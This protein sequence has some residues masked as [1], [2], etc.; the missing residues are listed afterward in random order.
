MMNDAPRRKLVELVARHGRG[1]AEEPRRCEAL[2]RDHCGEYRR[3]IS[4]LTS[5]AE[6]HAA[7]D[8][9]TPQ[10]GAPRA[11]LLGRLARRL[12]DHV[13]LTE[14]A[15][16]WAVNSWA[17]ALGVVS[18][19]ELKTLESQVGARAE[20]DAAA[21]PARDAARQQVVTNPSTNASVS[22]VVAAQ[23]GGDYASI[24]EALRSAAPGARLLVRPGLY[25]EGVVIDRQVEIVGDG[26]VEKII[27]RGTTSSCFEM[28][29]ERARVAGLTLRGGGG[30]GGGAAFFAVDIARG[31]LVL[32]D[33]RIS[34]E[35]LSCVAVHGERTAPLIRRCRIHDGADT[36][37]YFFDGARG[38]VEDCEVEGSANVGVAITAGADPV[39]RRSRIHGGRNAG[40]VAWDGGLGVLEECEIYGNR[41]AGVG[42]SGGARL[43]AR[44][45][46]IHGGDNS[47]VFVHQGGDA[48]LEGC[49]ISRHREAEVAVES[50]GQLTALRCRIQEGRGPGVVVRDGGQALLREC[51]VA[52]NAGEGV[53]IEAESLAVALGCHVNGNGRAGVRVAAGGA[54]RVSESDLTGNRSGAWDVEEGAFVEGGDNAE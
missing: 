30:R 4:A 34:S 29:A 25:E 6:E 19:D 52:G 14:E 38:S 21:P 37:L 17:L 3:E 16:R 35:T 54:A 7:A 46:R 15:A 45:C 27:V 33:C 18:D 40:V 9:L 5:A 26:P 1:L 31:V 49:D 11:A 8:L 50:S 22:I 24:G 51:A 10:A 48:T 41:L 20:A 53:S 47:G 36:G 2:L 32:E 13:A 23:G 12:C 28:R 42:V 39:V 44:A 43:S